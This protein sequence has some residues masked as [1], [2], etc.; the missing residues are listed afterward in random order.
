MTHLSKNEMMNYS[1]LPNKKLHLNPTFY[2]A[3]DK[4]TMNIMI[5]IYSK[6]YSTC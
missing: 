4:H 2:V 1:L 5:L 3:N 6:H